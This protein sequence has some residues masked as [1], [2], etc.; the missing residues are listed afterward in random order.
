MLYITQV[1]ALIINTF[2]ILIELVS[3]C[4]F[5]WA[6]LFRKVHAKPVL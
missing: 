5:M 4:L 3:F 6:K 2:M 1:K